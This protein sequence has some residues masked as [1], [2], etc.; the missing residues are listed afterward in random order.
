MQSPAVSRPSLRRALTAQFILIPALLVVA[1]ITAHAAPN[2][3]TINFDNLG[4][5]VVVSTQYPQVVFSSPTGYYGDTIYTT[6]AYRS[7]PRS[8]TSR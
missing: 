1:S 6:T 4:A 3:V 2:P 5:G 7:A 8:I